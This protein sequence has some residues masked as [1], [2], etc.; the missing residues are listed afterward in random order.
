MKPAENQIVRVAKA[1][2]DKTRVRILQDIAR[3]GS[4][5]CGDT[6]CVA[7]LSQ[8]AVSHHIKILVDA[9]LLNA[10]KKGRHVIISVNKKAFGE[11]TSLVATVAKP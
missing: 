3:R 1:L 8:P 10:E 5:S 6:I 4:V 7:E 2:A 9:G 11:F